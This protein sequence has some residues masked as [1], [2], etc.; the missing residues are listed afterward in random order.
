MIE[1]EMDGFDEAIDR[2]EDL[3]RRAEDLDGDN[4]VPFNELFD[5]E[6]MSKYTEYKSINEMIDNSGFQVETDE[7]FKNIPDDEWDEFIN[8]KTNFDNWQAMT[9]EAVNI[10]TA[11]KLGLE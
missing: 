7:D 1:F 10:W 8:E 11:K 2:L 4:N 6:F 3:Q 9:N 5:N